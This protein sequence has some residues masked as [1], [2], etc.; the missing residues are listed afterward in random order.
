MRILIANEALV[1]SGGVESYLDAVIPALAARGH[2]VALLY[3]NTRHEH[4]SVRL[5]TSVEVSASIADDGLEPAIGRMRAWA[6][7]VCFS[8]NMRWPHI[9]ERLLEEWP[10][11]KMMHAYAGTCVSGQ[12]AHTFPQVVP[13]TRT[14]GPACLGLYLPRHCGLYR[15]GVMLR[16]YKTA[17]HQNALLPKY[18]AIITA[19]RHM[20]D[21]YGRHAGAGATIVTA[22]LFPTIAIPSAPRD[23]PQVSTVLFAGRMTVLKG[24]DVLLRAAA[25]AAKAL[26]QRLRLIMAGEGPE[27]PHLQTL[28]ASLGLD[29]DFPGWVAGDD[30]AALIR[31]STIVV[32]PSLWP[33]PFGLAGLEAGVHGVP[34]VAFDVGGIREWLRDGVNGV[35]VS[36]RGDARALGRAIADLLVDRSRLARLGEGAVRVARELSLPA[37]VSAIERVLTTA[38]R[39]ER[40]AG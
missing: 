19:S 20:A 30:R 37:H 6:P 14:F 32:V 17:Q 1:G 11:V 8:H 3:A 40:A 10:V 2:R 12:K 7:D 21:E 29:A 9:E 18:A 26:P 5:D 13:C 34:A 39:A 23:L 35:L 28:A 33:E 27:R 15:P 24:A 36:A 22:P 31:Q 4:G 38:V 25:E 16:Q